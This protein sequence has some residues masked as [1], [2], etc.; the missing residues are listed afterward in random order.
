[1]NSN[2][3]SNQNT[4]PQN[5]QDIITKPVPTHDTFTKHDIGNKSDTNKK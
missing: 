2:N 3:Q 4:S 5:N 1:M